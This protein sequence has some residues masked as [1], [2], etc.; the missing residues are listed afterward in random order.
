MNNHHCVQTLTSG[1]MLLGFAVLQECRD[2]YYT[3][4]SLNALFETIN[5]TCIMEFLREAGFFYLIWCNLWTSTRLETW[6]IWSDFSNMFSEWK[7][8]WDTFTCV[9]RLICP[10]GRVSLNK[11]NPIM[12]FASDYVHSISF[13]VKA[14]GVWLEHSYYQS[15]D[16]ERME[17]QMLAI[18]IRWFS[19]MQIFGLTSSIS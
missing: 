16:W 9:G 15:V 18:V 4:H 11:T 17:Q 13:V 5:E 7:Q 1:H 6:T 2:D 3:V 12:K 14:I 19:I 10:E 8:L